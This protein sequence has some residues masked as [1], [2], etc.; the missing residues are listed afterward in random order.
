MATSLRLLKYL[1]IFFQADSAAKSVALELYN[2]NENAPGY[3]ALTNHPS[4]ILE[5][6]VMLSTAIYEAIHGGGTAKDREFMEYLGK[7]ISIAKGSSMKDE[8]TDDFLVPQ[9]ESKKQIDLEE[10]RKKLLDDAQLLSEV[11]REDL[12]TTVTLRDRFLH[13]KT[14]KVQVVVNGAHYADAV[15]RVQEDYHSY[16]EKVSPKAAKTFVGYYNLVQDV[17]AWSTLVQILLQRRD[18][19]SAGRI[20][21]SFPG[22]NQIAKICYLLNRQGFIG[23]GFSRITLDRFWTGGNG[24]KKEID[25]GMVFYAN[26]I[27]V[28]N[29]AF[30]DDATDVIPDIESSNANVMVLPAVLNGASFTKEGIADYHERN[31]HIIPEIALSLVNRGFLGLEI[32]NRHDFGREAFQL[33]MDYTIGREKKGLHKLEKALN[34]DVDYGWLDEVRKWENMLERGERIP[35]KDNFEVPVFVS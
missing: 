14:R 29:Q 31:P 10:L 9:Y 34:I 35:R 2:N 23:T 19:T 26:G 28:G 15:R 16:L 1:P 30:A 22:D 20:I 11:G 32:L 6:V 17:Q 25:R 5:P 7:S 8:I 27:T 33:G 13:L 4:R 21:D 3:R 18:M 12:Q 24:R